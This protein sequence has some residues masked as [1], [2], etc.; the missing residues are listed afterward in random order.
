V[1]QLRDLP[2]SRKRLYRLY[3]RN[4]ELKL[5]IRE[6]EI[7]AKS[8]P[9]DPEAHLRLHHLYAH[10]RRFQRQFEEQEWLLKNGA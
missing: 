4:G 3:L 1:Q 8:Y 9:T 6:L 7:L 5:A 2:R 10:A